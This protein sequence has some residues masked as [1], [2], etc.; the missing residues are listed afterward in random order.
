M[1]GPTFTTRVFESQSPFIG[2]EAHEPA[3]ANRVFPVVEKLVVPVRGLFL[4]MLIFVIVIG[5]LNLFILSRR[6]RKIWLLWTVPAISLITCVAVSAYS[7][8][9][10]GWSG[11]A[12]T[13][14]LTILDE[15]SHQATTIGWSA[16]YSPLTPGE[17]L[18]YGY[19]TELT[20]Q[21]G[22]QY[23]YNRSQAGHRSVD[24][25]EDQHL[26]SGWVSAR[27]PAHFRI[28]KSEVRRERITLNRGPGD[29]LSAVNGLGVDVRDLW[30]ADR[31]GRIY[32]VK[33]LKA[34]SSAVM[35]LQPNAQAHGIVE[36]LRLAFAGSD[37]FNLPKWTHSPERLLMP[38]CYIAATDSSPFIE[39][40]LKDVGSRK[41]ESVIYGIMKAE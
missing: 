19:E 16:F 40:G 15:S 3:D 23:S 30:L 29:S 27:V 17:G 14:G 28:R 33:N 25:T 37:W 2:A 12:R 9:S 10:E 26:A 18:H 35:A 39:D 8:L 6:K 31:D 34:G 4:L 11:K 41:N 32:S 38:G 20:P 22:S 13:A 21:I 24:W 7:I 36:E 1:T 5:P